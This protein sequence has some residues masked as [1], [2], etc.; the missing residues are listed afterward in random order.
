[1]AKPDVRRCRSCGTP[2][3]IDDDFGISNLTPVNE[4]CRRCIESALP[5]LGGE[6]F[7]MVVLTEE[8]GLIGRIENGR[9]LVR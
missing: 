2:E 8:L 5:Q 4:L 3:R 7:I 1:V 6:A 9:K